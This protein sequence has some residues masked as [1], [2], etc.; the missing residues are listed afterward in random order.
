MH[1]LKKEK[2]KAERIAKKQQ[3][4][5][6]MKRKREEKARK[7]EKK[8]REKDFEVKAKKTSSTRGDGRESQRNRHVT[9]MTE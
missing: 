5:E 9:K 4:E 7:A 1:F 3:R 8:A 2:R 6:E